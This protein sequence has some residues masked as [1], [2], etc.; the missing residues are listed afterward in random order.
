MQSLKKLYIVTP[1]DS[2]INDFQ[3]GNLPK[4]LNSW[5]R[6]LSCIF[7]SGISTS[8]SILYLIIF[9]LLLIICL[10]G[11]ESILTQTTETNIS[12]SNIIDKHHFKSNIIHRTCDPR[13]GSRINQR[14]KSKHYN[15][16]KRITKAV[17]VMDEYEFLSFT[18]ALFIVSG[19]DGSAF[20]FQQFDHPTKQN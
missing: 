13:F 3:N 5:I 18:N 10:F 17:Q 9:I 15:E 16:T 2:V 14:R 11:Y 19:S 1:S 4:E 12:T 8:N 6:S 20:R 7:H